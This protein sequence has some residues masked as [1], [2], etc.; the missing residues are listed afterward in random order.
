MSETAVVTYA[1][2]MRDVRHLGARAAPALADWLAYL[3]VD[4]KA[5]RTLY[6][7]TRQIA[8]LLRANPELE[9]HEFTAAHINAVLADKPPR[10]R[11]YTRSVINR[12]FQWAEDQELIARNPMRG[13]VPAMRKPKRRP[14]DIFTEAEVALLENVAIPDGPLLTLMFKTGIRRSEC[15]HL[16]REHID[17]NRARLI[18]Y[19]GKGDKDRVIPLGEVALAA[20]ANL[21]LSE[22]LEPYQHLWYTTAGRRRLRRDPMGDTTFDTWWKRC[23]GAAGVRYLNPHQTRHTYGHRLRERGYDLEERQLLMGHESINTTQ[24]YYGHLTI[25]DVAA[26]MSELGV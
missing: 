9:L 23:I 16:R 11:H 13:K 21:D 2:L 25:E 14:T 7:Y 1:D 22:Q 10:S 18:V 19:Q 12:W 20:V 15:R 4:T 5:E 8:P 6:T 3:T 24:L 17:L 26:K